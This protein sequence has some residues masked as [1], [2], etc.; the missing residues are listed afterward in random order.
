MG[1]ASAEVRAARPHH[2]LAAIWLLAGLAYSL[3]IAT[4]YGEEITLQFGAGTD[5]GEV[6]VPVGQSVTVRTNQTLG[7]LV[8]GDTSV[9]DVFPLTETAFYVLGKAQGR[10]NIAVYDPDRK[11]LGAV[12]VEVSSDTSDL[13]KSIREAVPNAAVTVETVNGRIRLSGTVPDAVALDKV[14]EIAGQYSETVINAL[15]VAKAQ[16][17]TLAVRVL[18]ASRNAGRE[19]GVSWGIG[20]SQNSFGTTGQF[21]CATAVCPPGTFNQNL[22]SGNRPFGTILANLLDNGISV[23]V[24]IQGLEAKNLARRLAEPNLVALSGES[25]SFLAGGEVPIPVPSDNGNITIEYKR[26]G[27]QLI[28]TPVVLDD[29]LINLKLETE[30]SDIDTTQP[31]V[32]NGVAAPSF[33]TRNAVTTLELRDGQSFAMA[34]LLQAINR[35]T[36]QQVPWL[37]QVPVLGALFRSSNYQKQESDLVIIVTPKLVHP[38]APDAPLTSPLDAAEPSND[39]E[40]FL[41]G[42]QEVNKDLLRR[43]EN[44][45]DIIGPYGHIIDLPAG[46]PHVHKKN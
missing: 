36:Q 5:L 6:D 10:T 18:E 3:G 7:D 38:A 45:G 20:N 35:R 17:V 14:M 12:D 8:V 32:V 11:L 21:T 23:D 31:V 40:F 41:L 22:Q 2:W 37:G 27:V 26:F 13:S 34:G 43:F 15:Q 16:Q 30:V 39:V 24:L 9:A 44:G 28:F 25:A 29:G 1:S 4:A 19:L 42:M 46:D 33:T